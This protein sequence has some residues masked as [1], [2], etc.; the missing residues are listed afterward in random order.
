MGDDADK[1]RKQLE[2]ALGLGVIGGPRAV[3]GA[4]K[5]DDSEVRYL[6]FKGPTDLDELF[7]RVLNVPGVPTPSHG[8]ALA[9]NCIIRIP[10]EESFFALSYSGDVDGWRRKVED[11]ARVLG[12]KV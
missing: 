10:N 3:P 5:S 12:L 1:L 2:D 8:G 4:D 6:S 11:G 9:R 7:H